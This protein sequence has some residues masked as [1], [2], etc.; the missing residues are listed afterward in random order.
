MIV[1]RTREASSHFKILKHHA[2]VSSSFLEK[3]RDFF[4]NLEKFDK[5]KN[6]KFSKFLENHDFSP[7]MMTSPGRG[8]LI[9]WNETKPHVYF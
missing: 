3:N 5:S 2:L 1:R 8:V 7:E 9:F 4:K 6:A